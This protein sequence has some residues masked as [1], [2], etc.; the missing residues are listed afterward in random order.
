[1]VGMFDRSD[2]V[3]VK[4]ELGDVMA[5]AGGM[6]ITLLHSGTP[7]QVRDETRRLIDTLGVDGGFMMFASS[8][9]DEA[10]PELV[11][12]WLEETREYGVY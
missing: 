11:R 9:L 10:D 3:K 1:M 12:V 6:P 4:R 7:E 5:I 2:M 8:V